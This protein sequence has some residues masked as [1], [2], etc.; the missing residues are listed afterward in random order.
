MAHLL[1]LG[2]DLLFARDDQPASGEVTLKPHLAGSELFKL[3]AKANPIR[4]G[5]SELGTTR[6]SISFSKQLGME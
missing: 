2:D 3:S 6:L 5:R 4:Q 1:Y